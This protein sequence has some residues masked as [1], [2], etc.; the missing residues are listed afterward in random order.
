MKALFVTH[1]AKLY[2]ANRALYRLMQ[3]LQQNGVEPHVLAPCEGPFLDQLREEGIS[4][5]IAP[6]RLAMCKRPKLLDTFRRIWTNRRMVRKIADEVRGADFDVVYSNSIITDFGSYLADALSLPHIWHMR[7]F[8]DL[9]YGVHYGLG[10][11]LQ[12]RALLRSRRLASMSHALARHYFGA[13][14]PEKLT[15]VYEGVANRDELLAL[16]ERA[17]AETAGRGDGTEFIFIIAGLMQPRKGQHLAIEALHQVLG[18]GVNA[19]LWIVGSGSD[20]YEAHCRNL[21]GTLGISDR[22]SF[23]GFQKDP[24]SL[25]LRADASLM[26]SEA[27]AYGLTTL[28]SMA[29]SRPVIGNDAGG[30]REILRDGETGLLYRDGAKGLADQMVKLASNRALAVEMGRKAWTRVHDCFAL[31]KSLSAMHSIFQS[32]VKR[33]GAATACLA[34]IKPQPVTTPES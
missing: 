29:C 34:Q 32:A 25:F 17:T 13:E 27:E 22:I 1:Y 7:E 14:C 2:G 31:E 16:K 19:R 11:R 23:L 6:F 28:E 9:D 30:T 24:I 26:C 5:R 4:F 15:V 33:A 18:K 3:G 20:E 10:K 21:A 12:V 8:G